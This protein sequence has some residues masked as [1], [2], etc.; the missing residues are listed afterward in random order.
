M[1]RGRYINFVCPQHPVESVAVRTVV[2]V[3]LNRIRP[4]HN[5]RSP[6]VEE[7]LSKSPRFAGHA[8]AATQRHVG[9]IG[10]LPSVFDHELGKK[11]EVALRHRIAFSVPARKSSGHAK[12]SIL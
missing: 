4:T 12:R 3:P 1:S 5:R 9:S 11:T 8:R 2:G 10:K 7:H 6:Q